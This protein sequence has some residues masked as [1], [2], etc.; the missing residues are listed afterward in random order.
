MWAQ[1]ILLKGRHIVIEGCKIHDNFLSGIQVVNREAYTTPYVDG[2]NIVRN[3]EVYN[4]SDAGI[5]GDAPHNDGDN[6]D[7]IGISSGQFNIV[8]NNTIY[9]NADD[10]IDVWRSNDSEIYH[11]L[12]YD[13]GRG[14]LGSGIGIKMGGNLDSD[15]TNGLRANAHHN[16]SQRNKIAVFAKIAYKYIIIKNNIAWNNNDWGYMIN[17]EDVLL[18]DNIA[19]DNTRGDAIYPTHQTRVNNSWQID[20]S[21]EIISYDQ[22]NADFLKPIQDSLY[23]NIGT[24]V[25]F[26][27]Q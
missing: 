23:E 26:S 18:Q 12:V 17:Y 11:N 4:N 9:G 1:W 6:A 3:N 27:N 16:I 22:N 13:H 5:P 20:G 15:S 14:G 7:G 21:I 25:S 2:W 19:L 24:Y 10:G 8:H